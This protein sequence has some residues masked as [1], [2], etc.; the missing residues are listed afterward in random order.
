MDIFWSNF[1]LVEIVKIF[2]EVSKN[3]VENDCRDS[4]G[5]SNVDERVFATKYLSQLVM[6]FDYFR[7]R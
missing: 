1:N 6:C 3:R 5:P 7:W 2:L 4:A